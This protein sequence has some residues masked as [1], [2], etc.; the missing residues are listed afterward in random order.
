MIHRLL[1][2]LDKALPLSP[3]LVAGAGGLSSPPWPCT[4]SA[5]PGGRSSFPSLPSS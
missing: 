4:C 3:P 2:S 1:L 5:G